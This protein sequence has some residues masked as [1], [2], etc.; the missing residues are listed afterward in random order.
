MLLTFRIVQDNLLYVIG[1]PMHL[2]DEALLMSR[3]FFGQYGEVQRLRVNHQPKD[4]YEGQSAVY[5][6]YKHPIQV[7]VAL[8]VRLAASPVQCLSGL[9]LGPKSILKCSFGTS[10]YCSNFLKDACCEANESEKRSCPFLHYL[11]RRRDK[12]IEDDPEFRD[13]LNYQE[14][15]MNAFL[16]VLGVTSAP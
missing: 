7:A 8:K 16:T 10:K 9:K 2:A 4:S 5:V 6:W 13:Y 11:E 1:I 12:V 15:I 3:R 14:T